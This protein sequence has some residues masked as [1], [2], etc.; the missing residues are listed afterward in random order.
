VRSEHKG[1]TFSPR[2][3][4]DHRENVDCRRGCHFGCFYATG[5]SALQ[6]GSVGESEP[7]GQDSRPRGG[8]DDSRLTPPISFLLKE[9]IPFSDVA[10]LVAATEPPSVPLASSM[11]ASTSQA[12]NPSLGSAARD[13]ATGSAHRAFQPDPGHVRN[14]GQV[15]AGL[16]AAPPTS[17]TAAATVPRITVLRLKNPICSSGR[18][19]SGRTRK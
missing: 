1:A 11:S 15:R 13:T 6:P 14:D 2:G 4:L 8:K 12:P 10:A 9:C 17:L 19:P 3:G 16:D 5:F 7:R 18:K